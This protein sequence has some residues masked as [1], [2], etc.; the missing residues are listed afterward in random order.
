LTSA[1]PTDG[2]LIPILQNKYLTFWRFDAKTPKR[3]NA[4]TPK[5]HAKET[6]LDRVAFYA[7]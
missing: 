4:K 1:P 3:Q 5:R 6:Q 2:A 7:L